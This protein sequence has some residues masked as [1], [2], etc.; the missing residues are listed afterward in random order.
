MVTYTG[1]MESGSPSERAMVRVV[2]KSAVGDEPDEIAYWMTVP[3]AD[4]IAAV[5]VLRRR[6]FGGTDAARLGLQ[7]VCRIT[8]NS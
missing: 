8:R 6:V 5:E 7:R 3:V 4:R 2:A 1:G